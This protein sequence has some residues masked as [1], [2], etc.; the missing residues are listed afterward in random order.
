MMD[1]LVKGIDTLTE[2]LEAFR[3]ASAK[4]TNT[5]A[6]DVLSTCFFYNRLPD[7]KWRMTRA[8]K[9]WLGIPGSEGIT[10]TANAG[11]FLKDARADPDTFM[12]K[13]RSWGFKKPP[14]AMHLNQ[15]SKLEVPI[16]MR[17]IYAASGDKESP[18]GEHGGA[19]KGHGTAEEEQDGA[20]NQYFGA[21][22][23]ARELYSALVVAGCTS[24]QEPF[25][26]AQV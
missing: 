9:P 2:F 21:A 24:K 6:S 13:W 25:H 14:L 7:G 4:K 26:E 20:Q 5:R 11:R 3:G 23:D 12:K 22:K 19:K 17:Q 18:K 1:G 10:H 8:D 16:Y 15:K